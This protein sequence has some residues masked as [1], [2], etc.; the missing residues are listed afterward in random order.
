MRA[1]STRTGGKITI[2]LHTLDPFEPAGKRDHIALSEKTGRPQDGGSRCLGRYARKHSS[3]GTRIEVGAGRK[4]RQPEERQLEER[5]LE[6]RQL[7]EI[8]QAVFDE[9]WTQEALSIFWTTQ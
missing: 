8:R 2:F 4:D 6:D 7:E 5:Q 3:A 1:S 9:K